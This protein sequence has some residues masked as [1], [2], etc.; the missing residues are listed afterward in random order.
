MYAIRAQ[1]AKSLKD[2]VDVAHF[3]HCR[4]L[5]RVLLGSTVSGLIGWLG[6]FVFY[7]KKTCFS[8]FG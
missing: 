5:G 1:G 7:W 2:Y 3:T 4:V 8:W 6:F